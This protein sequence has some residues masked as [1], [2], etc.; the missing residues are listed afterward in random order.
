MVQTCFTAQQI[1]PEK[2]DEPVFPG[3]ERPANSRLIPRMRSCC[4]IALSSSDWPHEAARLARSSGDGNQY[5]VETQ[6]SHIARS[7]IVPLFFGE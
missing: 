7:T 5:S 1:H 3:S 6:H 2:Q 4:F